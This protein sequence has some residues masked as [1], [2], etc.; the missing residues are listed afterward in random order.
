[1]SK[2]YEFLA[3]CGVFFLASVDDD[4]PAIRPFGAVME[5]KDELYIST[6]NTKSVYAQM[7]DNPKIQ[8]VALKSGTRDWIRVTGRAVEVDEPALKLLMLDRCPALKKRFESHESE[9]FALFR[10][11]EMHSSL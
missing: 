7:I 5:H 8:I 9:H 1:M 6:A 4:A 2:T 11:A 10:I 3:A